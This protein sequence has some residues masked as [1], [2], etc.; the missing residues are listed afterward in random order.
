VTGIR[1][2]RCRQQQKKPANPTAQPP[3]DEGERRDQDLRREEK[4]AETPARELRRSP[5]GENS[6]GGDRKSRPNTPALPPPSSAS[7]E[8]TGQLER[9]N[10]EERENRAP[11]KR[12][13]RLP[14]TWE[15]A[16]PRLTSDDHPKQPTGTGKEEEERLK[17]GSGGSPEPL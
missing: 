8:S 9:E 3:Q 7:H 11:M 12:R 1:R 16:A 2:E 10:R 4:P 6:L 17:R 5:A 13:R 15:P 14:E